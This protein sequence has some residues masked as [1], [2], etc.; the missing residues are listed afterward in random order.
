MRYFDYLM[1]GEGAKVFEHQRPMTILKIDNVTRYMFEETTQEIWNTKDF[2]NMAPPFE[3]YFMETEHPRFIN[4]EIHGRINWDGWNRMGVAFEAKAVDA[5]ALDFPAGEKDPPLRYKDHF[6]RKIKW[7]VSALI[8]VDYPALKKHDPG[9]FILGDWCA[10]LQYGV[11]EDGQ[12]A[13]SESGNGL[14][15]TSRWSETLPA[16]GVTQFMHPFSL[17]TSFLHCKNVSLIENVPPEKIN[18]YHHTEHE[19]DL[20]R[21]HTLQIEPLRKVLRHEGGVH[22]HGLAKALHICRGHFKDFREN[23]LFGK[24]QGIFWWENYIRGSK[25]RGIVIKDYQINAP[26]EAGL[27]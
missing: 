11:L 14:Y 4:S 17:A 15:V 18:R 7:A 6:G 5:Y 23:G 20:V 25:E 8:F 27:N 16:E 24:Y 26:K 19:R 12:M 2:P 13:V 21:F 3:F 22:Q 1:C 10:R 9:V